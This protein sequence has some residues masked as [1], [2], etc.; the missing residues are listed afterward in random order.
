MRVRVTRETGR[1]EIAEFV[2]VN[3]RSVWCVHFPRSSGRIPARDK[4]SACRSDD[5]PGAYPVIQQRTR[6]IEG[7]IRISIETD[8]F[9]VSLLEQEHVVV[10]YRRA[11]IG[12]ES[13]DQ[14]AAPY[15]RA[16]LGVNLVHGW[17]GYTPE[18]DNVTVAKDEDF[19]GCEAIIEKSVAYQISVAVTNFPGG[20][21]TLE[22]VTACR[23]PNVTVLQK[24]GTGARSA[25]P[26]KRSRPN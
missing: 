14:I 5:R 18:E 10:N 26:E 7:R 15:K 23:N 24:N 4:N 19:S 22:P 21:I 3:C 25:T 2:Q 20:F 13:I 12:I 8:K 6:R 17:H 11:G 9:P 16:C 1:E